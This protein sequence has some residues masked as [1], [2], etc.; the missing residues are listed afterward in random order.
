MSQIPIASLANVVA[1]I[2]PI[3]PRYLAEAQLRLDSLTKPIGSLG[4]LEAVAAQM[5]SIFSGT[6]PLPLRRAVYVFAADHGVT[7]E[8][9]SAYPREVT[10]QMVHNF[11]AGGAAINVLARLHDVQLTVVDVGVDAEF[12]PALGLSRMK[13]RH[14][15]GNMLREPALT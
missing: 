9:V 11:V 6:I 1:K 15:S 7:A 3:D 5:Y 10:A 14:G 13:V 8:G 4:R 12:N 2:E